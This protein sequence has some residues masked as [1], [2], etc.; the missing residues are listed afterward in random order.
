MALSAPALL[1][2]IA[3]PEWNS[4]GA[5]LLA[6]HLQGRGV[7]EQ[8]VR[9]KLIELGNDIRQRCIDLKGARVEK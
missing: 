8:H 4:T 1:L 5:L 3:G 6:E 2:W 7:P 9:L